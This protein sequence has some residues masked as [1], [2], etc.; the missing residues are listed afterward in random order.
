M[1]GVQRHIMTHMWKRNNL[2]KRSF[3]RQ[4][5]MIVF[6]AIKCIPPQLMIMYENHN[7]NRETLQIRSSK[8]DMI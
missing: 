4:Q 2:P 5:R 3:L 7:P 1:M 8:G 6:Y